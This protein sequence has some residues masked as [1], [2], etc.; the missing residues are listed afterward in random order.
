MLFFIFLLVNQIN[1]SICPIPYVNDFRFTLKQ[2]KQNN[3]V[4]E[5]SPNSEIDFYQL[6][7]IREN[8]FSSQ[9]FFNSQKTSE[10]VHTIEDKQIS[11][12]VMDCEGNMLYKYVTYYG[13]ANI[14]CFRP[15]EFSLGNATVH[16]F[17]ASFNYTKS[18]QM[19]LT[20]YDCQRSVFNYLRNFDRCFYEDKPVSC[21]AELLWGD[22]CHNR[23]IS[24]FTSNS[25]KTFYLKQM[26]H[27]LADIRL[28]LSMELNFNYYYL[29]AYALKTNGNNH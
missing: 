22:N 7:N 23:L 3:T 25:T 13:S 27:P 8:G 18:G 12:N 5:Y 29:P 15:E 2:T 20:S 10:S 4:T 24:M 14:T 9:V 28:L 1:A 16:N 17:T 19:L 26:H 11:V 21:F 6:V